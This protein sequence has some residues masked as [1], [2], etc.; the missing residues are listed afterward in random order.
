MSN[1]SGFY[2]C[3]MTLQPITDQ[4]TRVLSVSMTNLLVKAGLEG[5]TFSGVQVSARLPI[6]PGLYSDQTELLLSNLHTSAELTVYGP[7]AA[8]SNVEVQYVFKAK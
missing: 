4:Q 8:L 1:A 2:T 6:E 7:T 3:S 5:S